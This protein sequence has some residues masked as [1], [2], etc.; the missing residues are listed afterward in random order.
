MAAAQN[1]MRLEDRLW[2]EEQITDRREADQMERAAPRAFSQACQDY[3][4]ALT[5]SDPGRRLQS[6]IIYSRVSR[7][8]HVV[9][10]QRRQSR[11]SMASTAITRS[12]RNRP[13]LLWSAQM[14]VSQIL[15][16]A[17]SVFQASQT[18][19]LP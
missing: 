1:L 5:S 15:R 12:Q 16:A 10:S 9:L 14:K 3:V 4:I 8:H 6:S 7:A 19:Y 13:K 11:T 2:R 17:N 18:C